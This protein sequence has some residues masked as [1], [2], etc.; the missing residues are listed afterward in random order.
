VKRE[1]ERGVWGSAKKWRNKWK[2]SCCFS[3]KVSFLVCLSTILMILL[4]FFY[5]NFFF[6]TKI[7]I[8]CFLWY[9]K[10]GQTCQ[11]INQL[12]KKMYLKQ[13]LALTPDTHPPT[14]HS[15]RQRFIEIHRLRLIKMLWP[16]SPIALKR[17]PFD[18]TGMVW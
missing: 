10:K 11:N 7:P 16:H 2:C 3:S 18:N 8:N 5:P 13:V 9:I 1:K 12:K 14:R 4:L 6:F 17:A 15:P